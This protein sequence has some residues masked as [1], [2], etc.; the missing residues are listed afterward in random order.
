MPTPTA[1]FKYLFQEC[2]DDQALSPITICKYLTQCL[3][4]PSRIYFMFI[5]VKFWNRLDIYYISENPDTKSFSYERAC[6]LKGRLNIKKTNSQTKKKDMK[7]ARR[8]RPKIR[9]CDQTTYSLNLP[10]M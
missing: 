3:K 6:V 7:S 9:S 2:F 4:D 1:F 10:E 8:K 5:A